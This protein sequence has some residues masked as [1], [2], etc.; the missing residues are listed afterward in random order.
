MQLHSQRGG[1]FLGFIIGLVLGLAVA[2]AVAI[3]VTK[4]PTPFS[5]KNQT[6]STDQDVQET[7]KNK[8]WNPNSVFQPKP[9]ADA[10]AAPSAPAA[11]AT[12]DKSASGTTGK[13][14]AEAPKAEP[15]PAVTADPLGD[16]AKSKSGLS[17]PAT[18]ANAA[19]PFDYVIQVGAY[20]T[21]SDADAQKAK[22][23]LMGL[24]A[25]VSER[26]QAGRTVYR[27]RLGPFADK[28]AAERIRA[29]L[30]GSGIENTLVRVQR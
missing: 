13:S 29:R 23:A 11:D 12:T 16:L 24:D 15:R 21:S 7:E 8:D 28:A 6:R 27:V 25:K 26:D 20:R 4:V 14:A 5:N 3:Y 17:T 2:L 9:P 18:P 30:E 10:P 19:D 1:T 22:L